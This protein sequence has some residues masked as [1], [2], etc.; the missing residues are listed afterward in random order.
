MNGIEETAKK[1]KEIGKGKKCYI[2]G[3]P[4]KPIPPLPALQ[5]IFP[6]ENHIIYAPSCSC[7]FEEEKQAEREKQEAIR[8]QRIEQIFNNSMMT[9]FF[10]EKRFENLEMTDNLK[11]CKE[12]A[13]SFNKETSQG[14]QF[15]G[16]IGTGKT[17]AL[18]CICNQLMDEGHPCLFTTF[19]ALLNK[20]SNYSYEHASDIFPLLND[21]TN[22]DFVVLD[23]L[24]REN[25]T[26]KRKE[27]AFTIIDHLLN[28]KITIAITA[29]P[30]IISKLA[31]LEEW[32]A[33]LDRLYEM[34]PITLQFNN[35]SMRG[36][37]G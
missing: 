26:D 10:R 6:N 9:P 32:Q 17:T 34:C 24:G 23:D 19:S 37:N 1:V 15:I 5:K 18:A 20:F 36:T 4:Y 21:L 12:Y 14:L 30:N 2:C 31:K 29:N 22:C 25:Y 3:K 16:D 35:K 33:I 27:L 13:D 8:K 28:Y 11:F 7:M